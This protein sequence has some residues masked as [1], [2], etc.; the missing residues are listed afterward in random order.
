MILASPATCENKRNQTKRR[1]GHNEID[2]SIGDFRT[3]EIEGIAQIDFSKFRVEELR[4][5]HNAQSSE[6]ELLRQ[7]QRA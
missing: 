3:H 5:T 6:T 1:A 2:R 4:E 7:A